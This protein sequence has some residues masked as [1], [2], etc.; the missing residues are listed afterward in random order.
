[1]IFLDM[2]KIV[3]IKGEGAYSEINMED[4]TKYMVSRN[5]K[6]FEDIL[7]DNSSF[8][9]PHKS[10]IDNLHYV[11]SYNKSDGG[12]LFLKNNASVPMSPEKSQIILEKIR[13]VK[14]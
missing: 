2:H 11:S 13:L 1:L 7:H 3:Y 8:F 12:S 10:Y 14:R 4:G 5:L 6:N 9:R